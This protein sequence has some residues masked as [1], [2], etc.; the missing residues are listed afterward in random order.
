MGRWGVLAILCLARVSMGLHLQV[1]AA[2]SPFLIAD[3]GLGYG[4]IGTLIGIFLL[5][6]VVLSMPGGLISRRFGDTRALIGAVVL[7]AVGTAMLA[8]SSGFWMAVVARLISGAGGTLLTMQ[9][10]KIAT[11]WFAGRE[12]STAIGILLG[13]FPLG[14]A[15]VMAGLP[16]VAA[17][18][19][20]RMA[21]AL[22]AASALAT[23]TIVAAFLRDRPEAGAGVSASGDRTEAQVSVSAPGDP[24]LPGEG[25]YPGES[26]RPGKGHRLWV[27]SRREA[28]LVVIAGAAFSLLNAGLVI[29]TSFVPVL[30]LRRGLGE[31][32]ASVLT[33]WASWILI[34]TLPPSGLFLD[35]ARPVTVW[36]IV[37]ALLSALACFGLPS[38]EPAWLWIAL[39][40]VVFGPVVVGSM[41]LPGEVLQPETRATGF[42]LFF[43]TNY[44][45]FAILPA[46]AGLLV[47][48]TDSPAAP[49]WFAAAI[50]ATV[51]PLVLWF[52]WM[53]R[54]IISAT[55]HSGKD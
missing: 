23:L 53:Q 3:L 50:F 42:G 49:I 52:R 40:G 47:D 41:A 13:T 15:A 24:P 19:G 9:V 43:T 17:S 32:E 44:V 37:S 26:P 7:L 22:I 5:P 36:L 12:L 10:A 28:G 33:S 30:L 39:F 2:V 45:G 14:I 51:V 8:A 21:V 35:R 25:A 4:E 55:I 20:W 1:V 16:L 54:P 27:I 48:L 18:S 11:D 29:F 34:G 6:G 46:V 31:V 38:L